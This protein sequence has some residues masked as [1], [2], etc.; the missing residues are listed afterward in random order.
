MTIF[1]RITPLIFNQNVD[2]EVRAGLSSVYNDPSKGWVAN[3]MHSE[4]GSRTLDYAC[5]CFI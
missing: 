2:F 1:L 4:S 3:D 5:E